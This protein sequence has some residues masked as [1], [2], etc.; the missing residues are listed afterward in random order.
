MKILLFSP[1][2]EITKNYLKLID[3]LD[4]LNIEYKKESGLI[5]FKGVLKEGL[6]ECIINVRIVK[7]EVGYV[8]IA[9][10]YEVENYDQ[11]SAHKKLFDEYLV[12]IYGKASK[13][14]E[15]EETHAVTSVWVDKKEYINY[16]F[17]GPGYHNEEPRF[18]DVL[19]QIIF[20]QDLNDKF[21]TTE[22]KK[23]CAICSVIIFAGLI[24]YFLITQ[25]FNLINALLSVG[26]TLIGFVLFYICSRLFMQGDLYSKREEKTSKKLFDEYEKTITVL[27]KYE[28]KFLYS[29]AM[30]EKLAYGRI[31]FT[32]DR[33]II[34]YMPFAKLHFI[35][36]LY[37]EPKKLN[38][39]K[40]VVLYAKNKES[41][42]YY[43]E[44]ENELVADEILKVYKKYRVK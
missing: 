24:A 39:F 2:I 40:N 43:F 11:A 5:Y 13:I 29:I 31:Y 12:S 33:V 18:Q 6:P 35:E 20:N 42:N 28:G 22:L 9:Y 4:K 26:A 36:V 27:E 3:D 15:N 37:T 19:I 34:A 7:G 17:N 21:T 41:K 16:Y 8:N 38:S 23:L 25:N 1:K 44:V 10:N 30:I 14:D 32:N